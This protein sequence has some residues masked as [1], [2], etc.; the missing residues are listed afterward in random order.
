MVNYNRTAT[1]MD[2]PRRQK[3]PRRSQKRGR[4]K[5]DDALTKLGKTCIGLC[6]CN[7]ENCCTSKGTHQFV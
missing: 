7:A 6:S 5:N 1:Y 2:R 3:F 4:C